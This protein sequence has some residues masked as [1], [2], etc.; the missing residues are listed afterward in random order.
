[1]E[2]AIDPAVDCVIDVEWLFSHARRA[3]GH[4]PEWPD[5]AAFAHVAVLVVDDQRMSALH[6]DHCAIDSTTDVLTFVLS[7]PGESIEVE[8][9]VCADEAARR[10]AELGHPIER[11]LLLYVLHG[12]L[13][14]CGFDDHDDSDFASMHAAEDA[15][16]ESIGVGRTFHKRGGPNR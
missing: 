13:H 7:E 4:L 2:L 6:Q 10:A 3:I 8:I 9:A 11:E 14:C 5:S 16:L 12:L 1:M 15:I